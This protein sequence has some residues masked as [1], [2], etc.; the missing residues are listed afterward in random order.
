MFA[1]FAGLL[2]AC[3]AMSASGAETPKEIPQPGYSTAPLR[4]A[5]LEMAPAT[6]ETLRIDNWLHANYASLDE[7]R[8]MKMRER[9]YYLIDSYVSHKFQEQGVILSKKP[10]AVLET[11]F[12]W[13]E[14]LGIYGGNL[15]YA[16]VKDPKSQPFS[17]DLPLLPGMSLSLKSDLF[18]LKSTGWEAAFP[19][20]F[21]I[22]QVGSIPDA[23]G[24]PAE[25]VVISTAAAKDGGKPGY[26]QA[27][28]MVAFSKDAELAPFKAFWE[29]HV[30][31]NAGDERVEL[32]VRDLVSQRNFDEKL[33]LHREFVAWKTPQGSIA[34]V[35]AGIDGTYQWNRENFRDFLRVLRTE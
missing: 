22:G 13:A 6:L 11:L 34:V 7:Q 8:R 20:Y 25:M 2:G 18:N 23:G 17:P 32:G 14:P 4:E 1:R 3:F 10:D 29:Q 16:A 33:R 12:A 26:S 24:K 5:V 21:M 28:L 27:T 35:Y 9:L 30:P 19:Y 31:I 15:V